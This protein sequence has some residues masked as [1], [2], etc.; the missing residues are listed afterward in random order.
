MDTATPD[1]IA[2]LKAAEEAERAEPRTIRLPR[3]TSPRKW[4]RQAKRE[5]KHAQYAKAG[6]NGPCALARRAT[7]RMVR[8]A[9]EQGLKEFA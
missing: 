6:L 7:Q 4:M 9:R 1:D 8:M 5:A 2:K 3:G